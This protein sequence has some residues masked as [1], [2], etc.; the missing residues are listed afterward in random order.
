MN[1]HGK[2]RL[3]QALEAVILILHLCEGFVPHSSP[4]QHTSGISSSTQTPTTVQR[5]ADNPEDS[6]SNLVAYEE[7]DFDAY[8]RDLEPSE[9]RS[10][11]NKESQDY[12]IVD[13]TSWWLR[14]LRKPFRDNFLIKQLK[15]PKKPGKLILLRCGT[16]TWNQNQTFTGWAD[17]DLTPKGIQESQHAA[18]LMVSQGYQPDI[19]YTS[20]LKR[21]VRSTWTVLE[22]LEQLYMPVY[23]S[24]R[25]NERS[26]G[27]LTGLSK[28]ETAKRLGSKTVQAWRNS[29]KAR[30]PPMRTT[31]PYYPGNDERYSDLSPNQIPLSESLLD[32]MARAVPLWDY[33]IKYDIQN[34][35]NVLVVAHGN[36]LRGLIKAI[37]N[38]S[39]EDIEEVVL[40]LGIPFVYHFEQ[41]NGKKLTPMTPPDGSLTQLHTSG[42]FLG[43]PGLLQKA[44]DQQN[45]WKSSV[46]ESTTTAATAAANTTTETNGLD[47]HNNNNNKR[48]RTANVE[49][50]LL[51]LRQE[52][53]GDHTLISNNNGEEVKLVV[54]K[55]QSAS[56]MD[57]FGDPSKFEDFEDALNGNN[58]QQTEESVAANIVPL[59]N[60]GKGGS[61]NEKDPV[62]VFI[63]HGR[64]PHNNLGLFTGWEDPPLAPD[65][66]E[67]AKDAGKLLKRH[68]FKFDV[69]Y[70]SWLQRAIQT[71]WYVL[72]ELDA[73]HLP[74][75]KS[76]RLNE[77]MY[78]ALTGKSKAMVANEY[79]EEQLIKWRRGF[80]IRPPPVSSCS[81]SYPGND[82]S[83]T[84][85][86]KDLRISFS[87]TFNRSWEERRLKIHRKFPKHESL[88]DCMQRSV[89]IVLRVVKAVLLR[90]IH[91]AR[92]WILTNNTFCTFCFS[93][94]LDP[95]LHGQNH[96][97]SRLQGKARPH[98]K[99]RERD[100]W[101][102]N[103]FVWHPRGGN[104][105]TAPA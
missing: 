65:G 59:T 55:S 15:K 33:K 88:H 41:G 79:G 94:L 61:Q 52:Q 3:F 7:E 80:K 44:V 35:N 48:R 89:R 51:L 12:K 63:R 75:I 67:D 46:L 22:V 32:T 87:E 91:S 36:T 20:R 105:Q 68:G 19:V 2:L 1:F 17:P 93:C 95:I 42:K 34:G 71:A 85:Y 104:E 78:G 23:K 25:L 49:D 16:S 86:V 76:W 83:R 64:T 97:G 26:Y 98:H 38:I 62:V 57:T 10:Q 82:Y 54:K 74:M 29:L 100:S 99:P 9:A 39:E 13:R 37:D 27:A 60:E 102:S 77:R 30:P 92:S 103:A 81:L 31:D 58:N 21:A 69:V 50:S 96:A 84:K 72:D 8:A 24:W 90:N 43:K 45:A 18:Q 47:H 11:V 66:V 56:N 73:L 40:P 53:S 6:L 14:A 70:S 4:Y 101:Y 28:T 5:L